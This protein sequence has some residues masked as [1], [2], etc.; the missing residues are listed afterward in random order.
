MTKDTC[1]YKKCKNEGAVYYYGK[2]LCD[3]CWAKLS[4]IDPDEVKIALN[5]KV[6]KPTNTCIKQDQALC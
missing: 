2:A 5:I 4:Q 6:T 1:C 3:K